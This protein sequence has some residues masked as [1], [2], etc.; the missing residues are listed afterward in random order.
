MSDTVWHM[1][2]IVVFKTNFSVIYIYILQ[3]QIYFL[4]LII[5][6]DTAEPLCT[7]DMFAL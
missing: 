3:L 4:E 5:Y 6:S 7:N 2:K 1:H